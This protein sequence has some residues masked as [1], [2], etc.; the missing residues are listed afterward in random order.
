MKCIHCETNSTLKD[1]SGGRCPKCGHAFAFEPTTD[2]HKVTD[3]L[4]YG[5]IQAVSGKGELFYTE[6]QLWWEFNR[7][8]KKTSAPGC[9]L[10][11]KKSVGQSVVAPLVSFPEFERV[12]LSRWSA[13]HGGLEKLTFVPTAPPAP[14][15]AELESYSFDRALIVESAAIAAMLVANRFHFENNAAILSFD[16]RFPA[17]ATFDTV[18]GMLARNPGLAVFAL[19]DC[20]IEGVGLASRL[21]ADGWFP[22]ASMRI[23]DLGLRPAQLPRSEVFGEPAAAPVEFNGAPGL[24]PEENRFLESGARVELATIRPAKLMKAAYLGFSQVSQ[25]AS[26]DVWIDS[27]YGFFYIDS[28][29]GMWGPGGDGAVLDGGSY[30]SFG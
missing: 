6:R 27:G 1:R 22:D 12:Y 26:G 21:R 16:R 25:Y 9:A 7:F 8:V 10:G 3:P 17:G 18:R 14:I 28:G 30:D 19:H 4:F 24:T 5:A 13:V 2:P 29:Y 23:Y 20:S 15:P 11:Q